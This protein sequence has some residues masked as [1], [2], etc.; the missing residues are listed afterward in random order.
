MKKIFFLFVFILLPT[1][2]NSVGSFY[3]KANK[4]KYIVEGQQEGTIDYKEVIIQSMIYHE[5]CEYVPYSCSAGK[6][7]VAYGHVI[8][9]T[10]NFNY[11]LSQEECD[12]ILLC[13]INKADS[14]FDKYTPVRIRCMMSDNKR[15]AIV[16]FIFHVGSYNYYKSTLR[17]LINSNGNI[18]DIEEQWLRWSYHH[19]TTGGLIQSTHQRTIREF[20]LKLYKQQWK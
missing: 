18:D 16:K 10:D 8:L 5:G 20:E 4:A 15:Y 7:T 13:D 14:I 1:T 2:I 9:K 19:S 3:C 11:P 6:T 17:Q 12:S